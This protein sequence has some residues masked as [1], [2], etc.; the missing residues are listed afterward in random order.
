[1]QLALEEVKG[2]KEVEVSVDRGEA[3]VA[4]N[5]EQCSDQDLVDAVKNAFGMNDYD[6]KVKKEE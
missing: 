1:M 3:V 5:P 6:A 4:Y 2:V